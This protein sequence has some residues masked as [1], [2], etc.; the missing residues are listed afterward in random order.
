ML[1][2]VRNF[3]NDVITL[4]Q[5]TNLPTG[6]KVRGVLC[7]LDL[8]VGLELDLVAGLGQGCLQDPGQ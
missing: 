2:T 5:S 8:E 7:G 6:E 3:Q 1:T 4:L